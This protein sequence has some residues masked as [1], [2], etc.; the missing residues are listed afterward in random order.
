MRHH[1]K[2]ITYF[3]VTFVVLLPP[4]IYISFEMAFRGL[5]LPRVRVSLAFSIIYNKQ[6]AIGEFVFTPKDISVSVDCSGNQ[7]EIVEIGRSGNFTNDLE[8]KYAAYTNSI[9]V[10]PN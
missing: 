9:F 3:I 1:W 10:D 7:K 6:I 2:I 5:T 4:T 8:T